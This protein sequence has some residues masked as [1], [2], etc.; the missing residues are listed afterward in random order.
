MDKSELRTRFVVGPEDWAIWSQQLQ[1]ETDRGLATSPAAVLDHLLARLL[2]DFLV[3]NSKATRSLL[4][5]PFF[6]FGEFFGANCRG[7]FP[8]FD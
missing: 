1:S 3:D 2:E 8:R 7:V 4:G 5:N 6:S